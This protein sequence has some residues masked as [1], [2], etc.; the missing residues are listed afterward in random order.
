M[1]EMSPETVMFG[2][3]EEKVTFNPKIK[4]API[5]NDINAQPYLGR[6]ESIDRCERPP[7]FSG[8]NCDGINLGDRPV[9]WRSLVGAELFAMIIGA[10]AAPRWGLRRQ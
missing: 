6:E 4:A 9:T 10:A 8:V 3:L 2:M 7:E 1:T 5:A